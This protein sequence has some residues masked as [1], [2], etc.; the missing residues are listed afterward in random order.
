MGRRAGTE[1][2]LCWQLGE[3]AKEQRVIFP[4]WENHM[5]DVPVCLIN[6]ILLHGV[7]QIWRCLREA[8][9]PASLSI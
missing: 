3:R 5:A 6:T 7:Q 2:K 9:P 8:F 4:A 1:S